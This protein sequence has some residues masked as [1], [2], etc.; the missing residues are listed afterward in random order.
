MDNLTNEDRYSTAP[1]P[2]RALVKQQAQQNLQTLPSHLQSP[3]DVN[4]IQP[5][6]QAPDP[7]VATT[8]AIQAGADPKILAMAK[9]SMTPNAYAGYCERFVEN[10]QGKQ[11]VFPSAYAAWQGQQDRATRGLEGIQPGDQVYFAPDQSNLGYGHVGIFAGNNQFLS[12][13][14]NGV[15]TSDL[16]AWQKQTGQK[17]LGYVRGGTH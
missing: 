3:I 1:T 17:V 11:G 4:N 14:N 9:A 8:H 7:V 12:A 15:K 10:V 5:L 2:F 6:T 16:G 13:T